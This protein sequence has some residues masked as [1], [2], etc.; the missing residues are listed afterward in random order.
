MLVCCLFSFDN[1][2]KNIQTQTSCNESIAKKEKHSILVKTISKC[3]LALKKIGS[4]RV[5]TR[6]EM[7]LE[8]E[9]GSTV[10]VMLLTL[11]PLL[12][13]FISLHLFKSYFWKP[14]TLRSKLRKQGIDGPPPSSLLGNLSQ[15]KNLRALTP[16]TKSTE[17]NSITHAWTSN[18]FPHLELW[19][20]RYGDRN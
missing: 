17:H 7:E 16:Q 18:L 15:I 12:F 3:Y 2:F 6:I 9:A 20:N 1:K 10:A 19:R 11:I 4:K 5:N 8:L 13:F 14:Q